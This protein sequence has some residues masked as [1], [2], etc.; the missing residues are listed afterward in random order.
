MGQTTRKGGKRAIVKDVMA[1]GFSAR[2]AAKAVNAVFDLM[3]E[4]LSYHE[5]VE[6]PGIGTLKVVVQKGKPRR[7]HQKTRKI[8]T[9]QLQLHDIVLPGRRRVVKLRPD[10]NLKLPVDPV[11][12]EPPEPVK[13]TSTPGRF[14]AARTIASIA[15]A[16]RGGIQPARPHRPGAGNRRR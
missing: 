11:P 5:P 9:K 16:Y 1:K 8:A 10:P 15:H 12:P 7:R 14:R 3:R 13:S 2:K 4:A 6:M